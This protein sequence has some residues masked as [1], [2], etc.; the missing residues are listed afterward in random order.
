MRNTPRLPW[1]RSAAEAWT[2]SADE[3]TQRHLRSLCSLLEIQ[4]ALHSQSEVTGVVNALLEHAGAICPCDAVALALANGPH[5]RDLEVFTS[6]D[7]AAGRMVTRLSAEEDVELRARGGPI[8]IAIASEPHVPAFL[9]PL[10]EAG[11]RTATVFPM[12]ARERLCGILALG[13]R[14]GSSLGPEQL[15]YA[16]GFADSAAVALSNA[17]SVEQSEILAKYDSL[18]GLPNRRIFFDRLHRILDASDRKQR[19]A[20]ACFIDLDDFKRVNDT[21]GH[22]GGDRVLR[23]VAQRLLSCLRLSDTVC[24]APWNTPSVETRTL[25]EQGGHASEQEVSRLGGDEFAVLLSNVADA[26]NAGLVAERIRKIFERPFEHNGLELFL[27]ASIGIAIHPLDGR[28]AD[29]LLRNADT[30]MYCAKKRGK[31]CFQYYTKSMNTEASRKLHIHTRL[32]SALM[33]DEFQVWYQPQ[34]DARSGRLVG[35]EALLRWDDPDMGMVSPAEFIPL[36]EETGCI[37]QIGEWVLRSVCSQ[38]RDWRD[39]HYGAIRLGV[40]VSV[41]QLRQPEFV[42]TVT[43]ILAECGVSPGQLE[44][45]I[46]ESAIM[47]DDECSILALRKLHSMGVSLALDD[48]GTGYSSLS[49]LRRLALDR[50]KIDRSFVS[51]LPANADDRALTEAIIAMGHG[52]RLRVV[53]EGVETEE[54]ARYLREQGCDELQGFLFG[55]PAPAEQLEKLL[56]RQKAEASQ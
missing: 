40:N 8:H 7:A 18:T 17:L 44:V 28:D 42:E 20:A 24:R 49:Y 26:Q 37:G 10:V 9:G 3:P 13:S 48:F 38:A 54:Q 19:L 32:R 30:A 45:E 43:G 5:T 51:E 52:L 27:S 56:E 31:N 23:Q 2:A 55:R 12:I 1:L 11:M 33:R 39:R 21:L 4:H 16:I 29:T 36:A 15:P 47:Q 46:T 14:D 6:A 34:R 35:A 22:A 50:I 41:C 53:A 25:S